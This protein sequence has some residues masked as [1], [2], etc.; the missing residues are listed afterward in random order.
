LL[1]TLVEVGVRG[2]A[3]SSGHA[4]RAA[5]DAI[6]AVQSRLSRFDA[7]SVI[8]RFN[9]APAGFSVAL[10]PLT[11]R[12]LGAARA[13]CDESDQLFDITLGSAPHGWRLDAAGLHKLSA[14]ATLDLGGI[15][16]GHAVDCA[17]E[18]LQSAGCEAGWVNA[19][20]D[21]R[22]FGNAHVPLLLR[23]ELDGGVRP[24]ASLCDGAFAT[25]HYG[26]ASR[27]SAAAAKPVRAHAS[28]AAPLCLWA[29]ALTKLVAISANA[30]HPL[31]ER[32]EAQA[33]I[34]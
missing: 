22:V 3:T 10:D 21:V 31:L 29:D 8:A 19:G 6:V 27:S 17:V 26:A 33:W 20:G 23:D 2:G 25:S 7:D 18:A 13:L 1:G 4:I 30:S 14:H 28:V 32:Y 16:K 34:H 9:A 15:G 11:E 5:F 24:F 12:P